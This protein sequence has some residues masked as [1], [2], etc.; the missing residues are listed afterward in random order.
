MPYI[1]RGP[2]KSG[3]FRIL[4]DIS[5]DSHHQVD[6]MGVGLRLL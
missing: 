1:G 3:A 4:D 2:A 5:L 6:S